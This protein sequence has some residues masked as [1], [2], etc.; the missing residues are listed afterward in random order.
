MG[1]HSS[2]ILVLFSLELL[3]SMAEVTISRDVSIGSES[4]EESGWSWMNSAKTLHD[5]RMVAH[6]ENPCKSLPARPRTELT[7]AA[8]AYCKNAHAGFVQHLDLSFRLRCPGSALE[9]APEVAC[10][11][12][13]KKRYSNYRCT[14]GVRSGFF[15]TYCRGQSFKRVDLET[16]VQGWDKLIRP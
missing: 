12:R 2:C 16:C 1:F 13:D 4:P 5:I 3:S 6:P 8:A 7:H 15:R 14:I 10:S 9:S 11:P